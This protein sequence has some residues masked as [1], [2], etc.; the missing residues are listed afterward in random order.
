MLTVI[1]H[2]LSLGFLH[3]IVGRAYIANALHSLEIK[4]SFGEEG[5]AL[6]LS[7]RIHN[8]PVLNPHMEGLLTSPPH[9]PCSRTFLDPQ[10]IVCGYLDG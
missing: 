1:T 4:H 6:E 10:W 8:P 9:Y 5:R 2:H 3:P 7:E